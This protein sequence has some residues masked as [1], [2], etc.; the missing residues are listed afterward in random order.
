MSA[1]NDV[2][3]G[4]GGIEIQF[5]KI[6]EHVYQLG[7]ELCNRRGRQASCPRAIVDVP[8]YGYHW[9]DDAELFDNREFANV[10]RMDDEIAIF[11]SVQGLRA[12]EAVGVGN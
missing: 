8:S 10:P 2:E 1:H 6:V 11:Q 3:L 4:D 9:R 12:H 5:C 7:A